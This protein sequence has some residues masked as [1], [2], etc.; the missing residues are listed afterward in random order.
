MRLVNTST[1]QFREFYGSNKP[2]YAILLHTWTGEE[3]SFDEI[4]T[5]TSGT[6]QK[7]GFSKIKGC[8]EMAKEQGVP[9]AWVDSCCIKKSSDAELSESLN[10][11]FR[12][13]SC[14][15][16]CYVYLCDV[17]TSK[18]KR[19]DENALNTWEQ[20]FRKSRWFTRGWTLQELLAPISV[21]FFSK[22]GSRL[23]D[24][25][26]LEQQIHEITGIPISALK[27][28]AGAYLSLKHSPCESYVHE[29]S[30][31]RSRNAVSSSVQLAYQ[32]VVHLC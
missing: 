17:S 3:V 23:G 27:S 26:S 24:K 9:F 29:I 11:I 13:Y 16:K 31:R 21:E 12:W 20:A 19:G 22:K 32:K 6:Q 30:K 18:R 14:A 7:A 2:P 28:T 15:E 8:C 25:Q 1:L 5:P 4:L 10:S